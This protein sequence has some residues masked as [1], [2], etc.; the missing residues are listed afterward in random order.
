MEF[1]EL[2]KTI[3]GLSLEEKKRLLF[4]VMPEL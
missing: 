2:K 4:E 3:L 1:D